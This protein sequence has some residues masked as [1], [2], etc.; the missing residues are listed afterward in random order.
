MDQVFAV[1]QVCDKFLI[2]G[3]EEF[4][5]LMDLKKHMTRFIGL[6][7]VLRL[8]GLS[9]RLVK[10]VKSFCVNSMSSVRVMDRMGESSPVQVGL[11]VR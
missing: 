7:I 4:W 3:K 1:R 2:K 8:Y 9:S 10:C 11:N 6:W 5:A